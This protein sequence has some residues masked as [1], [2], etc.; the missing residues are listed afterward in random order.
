M[1]EKSPDRSRIG[2]VCARYTMAVTVTL[3]G[4][5][6]HRIRRYEG[7]GIICPTRTESGQRLFTDE[8]VLLIKEV[9][10]LNKKGI[11]IEGIKAVMAVKKGKKI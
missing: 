5:E 1:E 6:A 4:V 2:E 7:A 3:T 9:F 10:R 11:N 8:E